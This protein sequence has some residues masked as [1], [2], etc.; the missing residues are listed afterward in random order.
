MLKMLAVWLLSAVTLI[1]TAYVV[2][3]F[4]VHS[5]GG[6]LWASI[7]IGVLNMFIRPLLLFFALPINFLTLGLFT[8]VVNAVILKMA[9]GM[10]DGFDIDTWG[11]AIVGAIVLAAVNYLLFMLMGPARP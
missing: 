5:F 1:I 7:I 6:A 11:A 2:P 8:F 3:G 10:L 9:A 4:K